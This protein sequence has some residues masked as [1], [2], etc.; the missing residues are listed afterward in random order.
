M[1]QRERLSLDG[2]WL[3]RFDPD[4]IGR[5]E[6]W[7]QPGVVAWSGDVVGVN[8]PCCWETV[9]EDY[10]G[11]GWY[12]RSFEVPDHWLG[13]PVHLLCG[14][15][16]YLAEVYLN[17]HPIGCHR[18]GY[19]GFALSLTDFLE[20]GQN[21]LV[22]RVVSPIICRDVRIDGIGRDDVPHWRGA[23][24]G[25]IWQSVAIEASAAQR[26]DD[27]F[28]QPDFAAGA[29]D[30]VTTILNETTATWSGELR[31]AAGGATWSETVELPPG[32]S[33]ITTR[34]T[35]PDARPWSPED[36]HLYELVAELAD[37]D[38]QTVRYGLREFTVRD[39]QFCLN[40]QPLKL[41]AVFHEGLYANTL[42]ASDLD[43]YRRDI[44][45]AKQGGFNMIRPWRKPQP[46][47]VYDLADELGMLYV[48]T[49]AIECM[50]AWPRITPYLEERVTSDIREA[51]LRDR[52]HPSIVCW[53]LF[54][55]IHRPEMK[56]LRHPMSLLARELDPTRL[57]F[58]EAGGFAGQPSYYPPHAREPEPYNDVHLYPGMPLDDEAYDRILNLNA[59]GEERIRPGGGSWLGSALLTHITEI[60]YGSVPDLPA[61]MARYR[62]TGKPITPDYRAHQRLHDSLQ[63]ALGRSGFGHRYADLSEFCLESQRIHAAGNRRMI[64]AARSNP[65]LHGWGIHALGDGDWVI[66][67][68]LIDVFRVP[69]LALEAARI[70]N[71]PVV[72][73]LR[74]KPTNRY[75]GETGAVSVT[76]AAEHDLPGCELRIASPGGTT[77]QP[78][79]ISTGVTLAG[80]VPLPADAPDGH[81][82][83]RAELLDRQGATIAEA[84]ELV[85]T[86]RR[87]DLPA[88]DGHLMA[89][90]PG[91]L[92][93]IDVT[94]TIFDPSSGGLLLAN[95]DWSQAA[96]T[97]AAQVVDWIRAGG[98]ALYLELPWGQGTAEFPSIRKIESAWLPRVLHNQATR[99]LWTGA[100][101]LI[102]HHPVTAGLPCDGPLDQTW[103][104][105]CPHRSLMDFEAA[106]I[107]ATIHYAWY[108][109]R[110]DLQNYHGVEPFFCAADLVAEPVGQGWAIYSAFRILHALGRDPLADRLL[111]N[112]LGWAQELA[113]VR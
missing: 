19:T 36:P 32:K 89:I 47:E 99:G 2:P 100:T 104:S 10:E 4:D 50:N 24:A 29:I 51:I 112:L 11:V 103:L 46:P 54:N 86:T 109:G 84:Y 80:T 60:G 108:G 20:P 42:A 72:L 39:G 88:F 101:H 85:W 49:F 111:L 52:N 14:A 76:V 25:G 45:L 38:R 5:S 9:R 69:K 87:E 61:V 96:G 106:P 98:V 23:I 73:A 107:A 16:N 48:G 56:R 82:T 8:V 18:G 92:A 33:V 94:T 67:A 59:E 79:D 31:L 77:A 75:L 74:A 57:I 43:T 65:R 40:G 37:V 97:E 15:V 22:L 17:G 70:T 28:V 13:R 91:V 1:V 66:G 110:R 53:E 30:V 26:I 95:P 83:I 78:I 58:D 41:K 62:A 35:V 7:S 105:V 113:A 64:E 102:H 55:E 3:L 6:G 12:A 21:H 27:V 71:Q 44:E 63:T 68:G 90:R 81:S 93:G 34:L